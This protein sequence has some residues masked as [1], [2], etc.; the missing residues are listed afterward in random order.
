[1]RWCPLTKNLAVR[2]LFPAI[3]P[4]L[5]TSRLLD[6]ALVGEKHI[7]VAEGVRRLLAQFYALGER[8]D[9]LTDEE[10]T[11]QAR[12]RR[13]ELFLSQPFFEAEPFTKQPGKR[14]PLSQTLQGFSDLLVGA[15]DRLPEEAFLMAGDITEVIARAKLLPAE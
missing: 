6:P 11:T 3:D 7:T 12:G 5:S 9:A 14:V 1:M 4:A 10:N 8:T 13:V 15:Y 2:G